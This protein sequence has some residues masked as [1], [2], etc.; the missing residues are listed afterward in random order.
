MT[1]IE[2]V[3]TRIADLLS[4]LL[5]MAGSNGCIVITGTAEYSD[6]NFESISI[7][8]DDTTFTSL[9]AERPGSQALGFSDVFKGAEATKAGDL[10]R[11]PPGY[12]I[13]SIELLTGSIGLA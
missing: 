4:K 11:F 12:R 13:T 3:L 5:P 7:R 2:S 1:Y 6:L 10:L 8:E 9:I